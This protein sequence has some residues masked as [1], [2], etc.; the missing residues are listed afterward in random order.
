MAPERRTSEGHATH[1]GVNRL[2]HFSL[3]LGL[4]PCLDAAGDAR[5]AS[6]FLHAPPQRH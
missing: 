5:V 6:L 3:T 4:L 1:L 2:A